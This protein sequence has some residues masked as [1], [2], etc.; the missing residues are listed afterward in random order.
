MRKNLINQLSKNTKMTKK[1]CERF[2]IGLE[3]TIPELMQNGESISFFG[4]GKLEPVLR[5]SRA[6]RNPQTGEIINGV[7]K[8][9]VKFK[10]SPMLKELLNK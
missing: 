2:L 10:C 1:D 5:P 8:M 6:Y 4:V 7:E 9:G 3:K